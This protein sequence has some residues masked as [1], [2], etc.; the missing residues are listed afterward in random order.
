M[1]R[2]I[3]LAPSRVKEELKVPTEKFLFLESEL[4]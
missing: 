2:A 4:K 1:K 3:N